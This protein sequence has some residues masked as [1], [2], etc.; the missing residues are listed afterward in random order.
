MEID[1]EWKWPTESDHNW[2]FVTLKDNFAKLETE[3]RY[4]KQPTW[5]WNIK[6]DQNW[7]TYNEELIN[8]VGKIDR[9]TV[10]TF[11]NSI[12]EIITE[13]MENNIGKIKIGNTVQKQLPKNITNEQKIKSD[14]LKK[15]K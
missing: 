5:I 4:D 12:I 3:T 15:W 14:L 1:D 11:S 6:E 9:T 13:S 8:N 7:E 2:I 10:D